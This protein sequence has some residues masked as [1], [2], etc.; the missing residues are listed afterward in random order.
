MPRQA[1]LDLRGDCLEALWPTTPEAGASSLSGQLHGQGVVAV[2]VELEAERS[3]GREGI[4]YQLVDNA[5]IGIADFPRAQVLADQ[6]R[7]EK[8]HRRLDRVARRFCPV[9]RHFPSGVRWS[10]HQ[11]EN[12]TDI[13]FKRQDDLKPLY[14]ALVRTAIHAVKAEDIA[15]FLGRVLRASTTDEIANHFSTRIEGTRIRH[16]MGSPSSDTTA[17]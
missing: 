16:Q 8:L 7:V 4:A 14:E 6:I 10:I 1:R 12:A 13:V 9:L 5:F 15:I 3:P 17:R 2:E 11:A